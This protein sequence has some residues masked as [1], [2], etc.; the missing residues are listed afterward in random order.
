MIPFTIALMVVFFQGT[1]KDCRV[2]PKCNTN[3]YVEESQYL[4]RKVLQHF[5]LIPRLLWMYRCKTL[6]ELLIQHKNG[7]NTNGLIRSM[8]DFRNLKHIFEKWSKFVA[9]VHNIILGLALDGVYPF[10]D[11]NSCHFT[12]LV[13]MLNYN[14]P[15]WLVTNR[16]FFML[17]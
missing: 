12:W 9:K 7:T 14:L 11:L 6:V 4:P 16:Y 17:A 5:P 3:K 1:L 10:G 13:I 2:C 15:P 8:P